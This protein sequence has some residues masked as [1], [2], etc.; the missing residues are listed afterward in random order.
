MARHGNGIAYLLELRQSIPYTWFSYACDL[1]LAS[2]GNLVGAPELA[3]L[4]QLLTTQ[5]TYTPVASPQPPAQALAAPATPIQ[6]NW[7]VELGGF[8]N[9]KRL[10]NTLTLSL[11]K[12]I[13]II[14][15]ANGAGKSSLC[16]AMKVLASSEPPFTPLENVL[17]SGQPPTAFSFRFQ[18]D[19]TPRRWQSGQGFGAFAG[20]VRYFDSTIAVRHI[21]APPS[22]EAVVEIAP[23]RMEVFNYCGDIVRQLKDNVD[24][25]QARE[26]AELQAVFSRIGQDFSTVDSTGQ[27][28]TARLSLDVADDFHRVVAEFQ[29]V[30]QPE[31]DGHQANVDALRRLAAASTDEGAKLLQAEVAALSAHHNS[32]SGFVALCQ[33]VSPATIKAQAEALGQK[34]SAQSILAKDILPSGVTIEAFK[35]FVAAAQTVTDLANPSARPCPFCRQVLPQQSVALISRYHAFLTSTLENEIR[36][37]A[38]S[39]QA[40]TALLQQIALYTIPDVAMHEQLLDTGQRG[41]ALGIVQRV[42]ACAASLATTLA[43]S[44]ADFTLFPTLGNYLNYLSAEMAKRQE[45][46]RMASATIETRRQER[47]RLEQAI[48]VFQ[49]RDLFTRNLPDLAALDLRI[50]L[51]LAMR[52]LISQTNFPDILRRITIAATDAYGELVVESFTRQLDTE[53]MALSGRTMQ[54]WGIRL[55]R[56]GEAQEVILNTHIGGAELQRVLS[57]G[58][59]KIHALAMFFAEL[60]TSGCEILVFD[61]PVD[62]FDHNNAD[63]YARRLRDIVRQNPSLQVVVLTH[64]WHYFVQLQLVLCQA[65]LSHELGVMVLEHCATVGMYTERVEELK[66]EIDVFFGLQGEPSPSQKMHIAALLRRLV[67]AVVNMH[68]FNDERHQFKQKSQPLTAFQKFTK[69]VPLTEMEATTLRDLYADLSPPEHDDP[70]NFYVSRDKARFQG[71][72]DQVKAVERQIVGRKP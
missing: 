13:S 4:V 30:A 8:T 9:F 11:S 18:Q 33:R 41:A 19:Q 44:D 50:R 67:E 5:A 21:T 51:W 36:Q 47:L 65:G 27:W 26:L 46:L 45:A 57:E 59:K 23:F 42:K 58:E 54:A 40:S 31:R 71:W 28:I 69:L 64:N 3:R 43:S 25:Q 20:K 66:R 10:A 39:L 72:Y 61:D 34:Q 38:A 60:P 32:I 56:R 53:Y 48:A 29:P 68:V 15:G 35:Q 17:T 16:D 22:P 2:S 6:T 49:Y 24:A 14:F 70:R 37:L 12:R 62:S 1:A 52:N 63:A 7:L 55:T